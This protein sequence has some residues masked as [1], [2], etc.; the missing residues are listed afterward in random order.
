MSTTGFIGCGNMGGALVR[1]AAKATDSILISDHNRSKLEALEK[2]TCAKSS[3]VADIASVCDMI[4]V[5]VKPQS[6][7]SLLTELAPILAGRDDMP[8]LV[9]MAAGVS[10]D[11]IRDVLGFDVPIIVI[12]PNTPVSVGLGVIQFNRNNLVTDSDVDR[13]LK[14]MA[15]AGTVDELDAKYSDAAGALSGCGP[16]FVYQFI[17]A[18]ADGG[19][20]CGLARDKALKYAALTV[21]GAAGMVLET[22]L[23]PGALKDAVCSPGGSTIEGVYAL[24][25]SGF[26]GAVMRAVCDAYEK[27]KTLGMK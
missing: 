11:A 1:A 17:E 10:A 26:R 20:K 12:K 19:V 8:V 5:G 24:E 15:Y 2:D 21:K 7:P 18:L 14:L 25:E 9:S 16:A 27:T 13:F 22:G 23:H 3:T 4:F 6:L